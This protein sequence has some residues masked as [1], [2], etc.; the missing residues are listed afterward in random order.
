MNN[1][2]RCSGILELH[3]KKSALSKSG[4][5]L[6]LVN[7]PP[8]LL[9]K[10]IWALG[11]MGEQK[12]RSCIFSHILHEDETVRSTAALALLRLGDEQA[13]HHCL[14]RASSEAWA[15]LPMAI[16]CSRNALE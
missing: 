4:L 13:L 8:G 10:T 14:Q 12:A 15:I 7:S 3:G 1:D 11:R 9:A 5:T 6:I 2:A 16:G